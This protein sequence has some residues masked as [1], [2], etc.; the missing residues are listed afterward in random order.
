[1][2]INVEVYCETLTKLQQAI[3]TCCH[4][5][6]SSGV[7]FL[8]DNAQPHTATK[9]TALLDQFGWGK[10]DHLPYS[11]DLAPLDFHLFPKL[12][13]FLGGKQMVDDD[14]LKQLSLLVR[15]DRW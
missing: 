12:K 7:C 1:M 4:G 3:Q 14:E 2:T 10:L 9:T 15:T 5:L 6:L 13:E 11:P 8:N